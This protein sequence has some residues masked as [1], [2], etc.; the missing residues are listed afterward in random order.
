[1]TM[2]VNDITED[3]ALEKDRQSVEALRM[4]K[5]NGAGPVIRFSGVNK[6]YGP[7]HVLKNI[8][9]EIKEGQVVVVCGPSG[10]G[11]STLIRCVNGLE[12]IDS[13]ELS[14]L[15]YTLSRSPA[16]LRTIRR[17]VGMVVQNFRSERSR[18][19]KGCGS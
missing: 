14:V 12:S 6:H 5:M 18:V 11:K 7:L 13:G 15:K 3:Q 10:S 1:M 17:D 2:A 4:S 8:D 9:L 16:P 19:G